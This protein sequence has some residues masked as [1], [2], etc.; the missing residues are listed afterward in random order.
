MNKS[1]RAGFRFKGQRQDAALRGNPTD[2]GDV[3]RLK[4]HFCS[5]VPRS[6]RRSS[7]NGANDADIER[8]GHPKS[9]TTLLCMDAGSGSK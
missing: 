4:V 7:A 9:G 5:G 3:G 6:G 2:S 8:K 1:L